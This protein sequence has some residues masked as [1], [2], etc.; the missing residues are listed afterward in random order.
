MD[1][2]QTAYYVLYQPSKN[3]CAAV[4]SYM[5]GYFKKN[6]QYYTSIKD[7]ATGDIVFFQ[8]SEGLSH[9]GICVDWSDT[10][11]TFTTVE[12]NKGNKV[13]KGVY[14]YSEVGGY[15]AGF[16]KPR[17][18][19]DL[20][21]KAFIEYAISQVG[22]TEG[23]NNWNKYAD[24]LDKVNY[25]E[26]C[27]KKQNL[28][29]CA[30]FVC[31]CAYNA[32]NSEP[33]P[34][35][36][37]EPP[38]PTDSYKVVTEGNALRIRLE[39][40]TK[41]TQAGFINNG[42]TIKA[43]EVVKGEDVNGVNTWVKTSSGHFYGDYNVGYASGKYLSPTP[44]IEEPEPEPEPQPEPAKRYKVVT[45]S[46]DSLRIRQEPTT[47]SKQVGFIFNG[48]IIEVSEI[49]EGEDVDGVNTWALTD[50]GTHYEGAT[51]GYCST[52]YL[53]EV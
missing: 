10:N 17:F 53:K 45:N 18:T 8:N 33:T 51:S 34:P 32:Y 52:K 15:V 50:Y 36:P 11:K 43:I 4:V 23:A 48:S 40:N 5:A 13:A 42:E 41:S 24:E 26:G 46:G 14:K 16:G 47:D 39:P 6:K 44:I 29:W 38:K 35:T 7:L 1:R 37:P 30:V 2:K 27:G 3:N 12:G 25:F 20:T 9:V 21:R 31:A 49:V 19:D 28:P 22:Y